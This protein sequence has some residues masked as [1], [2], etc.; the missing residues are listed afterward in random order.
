MRPASSWIVTG[1]GNTVRYLP[2]TTMLIAAHLASLRRSGPKT[3]LFADGTH[4]RFAACIQRSI[5]L[6][7]RNI[8][9]LLAGL[10]ESPVDQ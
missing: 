7:Y 3:G 5:L 6:P 9:Q 10:S 1:F 4:P 2:S 8:Q